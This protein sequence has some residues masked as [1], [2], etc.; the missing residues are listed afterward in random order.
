MNDTLTALE[1]DILAHIARR[2]G[3]P[4]L[5]AQIRAATVRD[6]DFTGVG[7]YTS[8][9]LRDQASLARLSSRDSPLHGPSI[10]SPI[11]EHG[12]CSLLWQ[13][14]G[15]LD[16]IEIAASGDFYPKTEFHYSIADV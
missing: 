9:T 12:A 1:R 15:Y 4:A 3:D 13:K 14:D 16:C 8:F 10:E 2:V 7:L 6:R 11:L 5:D